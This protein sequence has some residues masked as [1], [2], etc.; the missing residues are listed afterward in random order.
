MELT[1]YIWDLYKKSDKAER[2]LSM[3]DKGNIDNLS[4][5][6]DFEIEFEYEDEDGKLECFHSYDSMIEYL[7]DVEIND[8]SDAR[9][10]YK[11]I[12]VDPIIE[13]K[14]EKYTIFFEFIGAFSTA[15]Y[16]RYPDYFLPYYFTRENYSDFLRLC[17]NF[18]IVLPSNPYRH[19]QEKRVWFY[20]DICETLHQFRRKH[21][22]SS[23]DFPA[24]LYHFG[25]K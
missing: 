3:F 4:S 6:F 24:L 11:E 10:L 12:V 16:H 2:E 15:L 8:F 19:S 25:I 18:G 9:E 21:N 23:K 20:F 5:Q 22:I 1:E 7:I 14:E 13:A 17:D